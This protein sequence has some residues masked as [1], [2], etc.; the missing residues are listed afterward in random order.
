MHTA[1]REE[2]DQTLSNSAVG[3]S[4]EPQSVAVKAIGVN[5]CVALL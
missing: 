4:E 3:L 5:G 2:N 1:E